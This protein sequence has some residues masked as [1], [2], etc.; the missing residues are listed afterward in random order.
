M[1]LLEILLHYQYVNLDTGK[2]TGLLTWFTLLRLGDYK[3]LRKR[4]RRAITHPK[5]ARKLAKENKVGRANI[6]SRHR[7]GLHKDVL[8]HWPRASKQGR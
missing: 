7:R 8:R 2:G 4:I 1:K 6:A 5:L 3:H